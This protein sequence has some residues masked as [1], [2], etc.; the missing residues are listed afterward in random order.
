MPF[1]IG[2]GSED[3]FKDYRYFSSIIDGAFC[4]IYISNVQPGSILGYFDSAGYIEY[5]NRP[6]YSQQTC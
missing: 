6:N 3:I 4:D 2:S 1:A 5:D